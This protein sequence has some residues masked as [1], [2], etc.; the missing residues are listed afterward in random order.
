MKNE[1]T[2]VCSNHIYPE[3]MVRM[4]NDPESLSTRAVLLWPRFLLSTRFSGPLKLLQMQKSYLWRLFL[5]LSKKHVCILES[6]TLVIQF[7]YFI[8][9][10]VVERPERFAY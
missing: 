2:Y 5:K 6:V 1:C 7:I 8:I 9:N 4:I 10:S 3:L